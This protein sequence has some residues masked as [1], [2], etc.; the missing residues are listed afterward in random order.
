MHCQNELTCN[1]SALCWIFVIHNIIRLLHIQSPANIIFYM[2]LF[3]RGLSFLMSLAKRLTSPRHLVSCLFSR[4]LMTVHSFTLLF[5]PQWP[6]IIFLFFTFGTNKSLSRLELF[7]TNDVAVFRSRDDT[8][9]DE[10]E[11]VK[12]KH[13]NLLKLS[14]LC[15]EISRK[16][17]KRKYFTKKVVFPKLK[18]CN[19]NAITD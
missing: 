11:S 14:I 9:S 16:N 18:H 19:N 12:L 4:D 5:V 2:S 13:Q 6:F 1:N 17:Y 15:F 8:L 3:W 10:G 7:S